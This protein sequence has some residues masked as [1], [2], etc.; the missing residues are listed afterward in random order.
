L[1]YYFPETKENQHNKNKKLTLRH[2]Y[3][4]VL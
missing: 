4:I 2:L 1:P 3:L